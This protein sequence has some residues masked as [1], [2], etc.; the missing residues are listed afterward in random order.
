VI[1]TGFRS[2][3]GHGR[4]VAH[5]WNYGGTLALFLMAGTLLFFAVQQKSLPLPS[6][7][8]YVENWT[9]F[10]HSDE[11]ARPVPAPTPMP[12]DIPPEP[13]PPVATSKEPA[14]VSESLDGD[15][16]SNAVTGHADVPAS[17]S[18]RKAET[19]AKSS[20]EV[21]V[22]KRTTIKTRTSAHPSGDA[23][24]SDQRLEVEIYKAIHDRA[25]LGVQVSWVNDGM[26]YL[27]GRVASPRQKLAAV[28]AALSV[29]GVKEVRD[30]IVID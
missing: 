25:I 5:T 8:A 7:T 3:D 6:L 30:R 4:R 20:A 17:G 21:A 13:A 2:S 14:P 26:V 18:D 16:D 10:G 24:A 23:V 9:G 27:E 15:A 12:T 29:A 22:N 28:R 1:D 19:P 11:S